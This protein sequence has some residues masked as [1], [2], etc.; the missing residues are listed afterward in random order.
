M[1]QEVVIRLKVDGDTDI[2]QLQRELEKTAKSFN[3]VQGEAQETSSSLKKVGENGG[4]IATLDNLTGGLASRVRDAAEATKVFNFNL[5]GTRTA[6]I[7]T[8]IG[9]FVVALGLVVAY[10]DD[11]VDFVKQTN[12]ALQEQVDLAKGI[13]S[14]LEAELGLIESQIK[15]NEKQGIV[16]EELQKQR[17]EINK[18]I[19][20]A[21][22]LE[23]DGLRHQLARLNATNEELGIWTAIRFE[24]ARMFGGADGLAAEATK[25]ANKRL[26]AVKELEAAILAAEQKAIDLDIALFDLQNPQG[27]QRGTGGFTTGAS[28]LSTQQLAQ[29]QGEELVTD[30]TISEFQKRFQAY[31]LLLLEQA[32][33]DKR[34]KDEE[35]ARERI[36]QQAKISIIEQTFG[37]I[38]GILGT[39]SKAGK[40]A[41]I[42]Q[43]LIN[44]YQGVTEVWATKSTLPEPFATISRIAST[45]TVLGSGLQ[46]VQAIKSTQLPQ[47]PGAVGGF[48]A[49]GG[50]NIASVAQPSFNVIG[51]T[52]INQLNDAINE[53]NNEPVEA[54][55]TMGSIERGQSIRRNSINEASI[56]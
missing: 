3:E 11:I 1:A 10:W 30:A 6:L 50:G 43:A 55:V 53:R 14:T 47:I 21:N 52:G 23:L 31:N 9:A 34:A 39:N 48:S 36:L 38:A 24:F 4:A 20:K 51:N 19:Q 40:A 46:A 42:A 44:T 5:K 45:A 56:G 8:G 15:F 37:A 17:I 41:A 25:Q 35:L 33:A 2:N 18:K 26:L 29:I 16:N 27:E 12:E 49:G 28:E 13:Q 32:G 22:E 54:F 7:A